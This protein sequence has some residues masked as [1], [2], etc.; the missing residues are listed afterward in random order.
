MKRQQF[1]LPSKC[2]KATGDEMIFVNGKQCSLFNRA[3]IKTTA[4]IREEVD[5]LVCNVDLITNNLE[6]EE[7]CCF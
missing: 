4:N 6:E 1:C 7:G 2:Q 3:L 5:L